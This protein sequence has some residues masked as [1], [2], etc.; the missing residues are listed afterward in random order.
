MNF[1]FAVDNEFIPVKTITTRLA[2][3]NSVCAR[4][5]ALY[6]LSRAEILPCANRLGAV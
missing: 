3:Q 2:S 5:V 6:L 4:S 1:I